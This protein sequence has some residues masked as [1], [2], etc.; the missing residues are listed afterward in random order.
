MA[1]AV[2][3]PME[4]TAI[5]PIARLMSASCSLGIGVLLG[6][7]VLLGGLLKGD[8][9]IAVASCPSGVRP[10]RAVID[11]MVDGT[12][13]VL[14]VEPDQRE[15]IIPRARLPTGSSEGAWLHIKFDAQV[16]DG[17]GDGPTGG[18]T[19]VIDLET[20]K[21]ARAAIAVKLELLRRRLNRSAKGD[22]E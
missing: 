20:T 13:A 8:D 1:Q 16:G 22:M 17:C 11:R 14:L 6:L 10:V 19:F 7:F 18:P 12:Y 3:R 15:W 2:K 21:E 5:R 9:G 4:R